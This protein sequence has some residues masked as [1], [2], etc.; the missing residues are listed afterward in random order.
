MSNVAFVIVSPTWGPG[1][2][3]GAE[4]VGLK[5]CMCKCMVQC[6]LSLLHVLKIRTYLS[7]DMVIFSQHNIVEL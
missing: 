4:M 1:G 6:Q 7:V 3:G 2:G 5:I